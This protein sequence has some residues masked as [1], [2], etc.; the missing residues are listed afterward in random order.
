MAGAIGVNAVVRSELS[1]AYRSGRVKKYVWGALWCACF[2]IIND[3]VNYRRSNRIFK[4]LKQITRI[5]L[6]V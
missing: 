5:V 2:L 4:L 3:G 6:I 1:S